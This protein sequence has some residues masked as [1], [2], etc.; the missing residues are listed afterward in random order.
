MGQLHGIPAVLAGRKAHAIRAEQA[1]SHGQIA[2]KIVYNQDV[3]V[4]G[5]EADAPGATAFGFVSR[6]QDRGQIAHGFPVGNALDD[7]GGKGGTSAVFAGHCNVALH[8]P[9][10]AEGYGQPQA[11]AFN[12]AVALFIN[13]A[14]VAKQFGHI[15]RFYADALVFN[16]EG[17]AYVIRGQGFA[18]G[19]KTN[20]SLFGIFYGIAQKIKQNLFDSPDVSSHESGEAR[21]GF[22]QQLQRLGDHLN[23]D[24]AESVIEHVRS[25]IDRISAFQ[26]PGFDFG[27]IEEV[28]DDG[29]K[30]GPGALDARKIIQASRAAKVLSG[31]LAHADD[32]V[33][34]RSQLVAYA[35]DEA[36]FF[37]GESFCRQFALAFVADDEHQAD[38]NHQQHEK[39]DQHGR[40][41]HAHKT[42]VDIGEDCSF[43]NDGHHEPS[44]RGYGRGIYG[45]VLIR[46]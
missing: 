36:G 27:K 45:R 8:G 9:T 20:A 4:R 23:T 35:G 32:R 18:A 17:Q 15:F 24:D 6:C 46:N 11:R 14:E 31:Q 3:G 19:G 5:H 44:G 39:N 29:Q 1:F 41:E 7:G 30:R 22:H 10:Q 16:H 34:R 37:P 13:A 25:G 33:H 26:A 43:R 28:V 42:L 40:Q 12:G 2:G 21:R 38:Q